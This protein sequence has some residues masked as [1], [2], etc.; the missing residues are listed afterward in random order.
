MSQRFAELA[1]QIALESPPEFRAI[2][3]RMHPDFDRD[4]DGNDEHA[5]IDYFAADVPDREAQ[6]AADYI[7]E[8]LA[9]G[10]SRGELVKIWNAASVAANRGD[11]GFRAKKF[12]V[13]LQKLRDQLRRR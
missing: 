3:E 5:L 4:I 7:D 1:E 11:V 6:I 12:D 9:S 13:F 10:K 8:L 2:A